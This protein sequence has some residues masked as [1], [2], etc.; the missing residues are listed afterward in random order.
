M[1]SIRPT[2]FLHKAKS[3]SYDQVTNTVRVKVEDK[4]PRE[5][6]TGVKEVNIRF[7]ETSPVHMEAEYAGK[8]ILAVTFY[9]GFDWFSF[10]RVV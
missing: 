3:F 7:E 5:V 8:E 10:Y 1:R 6:F 9:W 2:H 4:D